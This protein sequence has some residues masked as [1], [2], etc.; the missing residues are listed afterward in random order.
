MLNGDLVGA[1]LFKVQYRGVLSLKYELKMSQAFVQKYPKPSVSDIESFE[2]LNDLARILD[3]GI[4]KDTLELSK[5]LNIKNALLYLGAS[6]LCRNNDGIR[7]NFYLYLNPKTSK[8]EFIPWDLDETF[9]G[10]GVS[11]PFINNLFEQ[12]EGHVDLNS[13]LKLYM[14]DIWREANLV[15]YLDS[16]N[17]VIAPYAS[18]QYEYFGDDGLIYSEKLSRL[19]HFVH[20][21]DRQLQ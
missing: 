5:V 20:S 1:A 3:K 21:V 14:R 2:K 18:V 15:R 10:G 7:N 4:I 8:F 19:E 13:R 12:L 9:G 16:M 11:G 6:K 17:S